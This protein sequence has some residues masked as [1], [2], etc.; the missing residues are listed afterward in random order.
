MRN[1]H[2]F[3]PTP[4]TV[5]ERLLDNI[6]WDGPYWEPCKGDGRLVESILKRG[7][8]VIAGDIQ[9]GQNFFEIER[10]E[11]TTL[12][13]NPPFKQIRPFIDHAFAIGV[14]R[15]ALVC[16]ERLWACQA[17][18]KQMQRHRPTRFCNMNWREDYLGKGGSPDRALAV[19]IWETPSSETCQFEV[20]DRDGSEKSKDQT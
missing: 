11:V 3:Y 8:S 7:R 18:F 16:P 14:E 13:T 4:F 17:G 10:A 6:D 12:V 19:S 5:I 9:T 20:W 15:M 2:D 1:K